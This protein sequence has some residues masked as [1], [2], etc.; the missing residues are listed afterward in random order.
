MGILNV[1]PDSFFDGNKHNSEEKI[2]AH[3]EKMIADGAS[4]IDIG[5]YSTRPCAAFVSEKEEIERLIPII[6][7]VRN[8]FQDVIISV[9]TFRSNV[10]QQA[11]NA[12][13]NMINDVF[14]GIAD[15]NIFTTAAK[16]N[17]PIVIMHLKGEPT[18]MQENP[19][20]KNVTTEVYSHL[21]QRTSIAKSKGVNQLIID[22]GFGF[23]K[24]LKHNYELLNNLE[25]FKELNFPLLVGLSR[26]SMI[27]K[28]LNTTP[29][30]ALNGTTAAH[31]IALKNGAN[32]LRVHDVK[33]ASEAIKIVSFAN[34]SND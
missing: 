26:K 17:I 28:V 24:T 6:T 32:I 22:V 18:N 14:G 16:N 4:I 12:G 9:D 34:Q 5:G 19:Q 23:G 15:E 2:L 7:A 8:N 25:K 29:E 13:A 1:T 10:A 21:Q 30:N 3:V 27:Y 33:E 11:V 20:Y 31:I